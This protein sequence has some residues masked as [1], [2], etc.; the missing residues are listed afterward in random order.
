MDQRQ[1]LLDEVNQIV[2]PDGPSSIERGLLLESLG[3]YL[4]DATG[5]ELADICRNIFDAIYTD[6]VG[7]RIT[8]FRP[9]NEFWDVFHAAAQLSNWKETDDGQFIL[10]ND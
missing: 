10:Q 6:F 4:K 2:V 7:S 3:E 8:R 9:A 1:K 5:T